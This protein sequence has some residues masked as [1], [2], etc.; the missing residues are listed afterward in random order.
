MIKI[1][2]AIAALACSSVIAIAGNT[3][4][5]TDRNAPIVLPI[6]P[7]NKATGAPGAIDNMGIGQTT[8]APGNFTNLVAQ[9]VVNQSMPSA[10][11]VVLPTGLGTL[12]MYIGDVRLSS[13]TTIGC[14]VVQRADGAT[15][16]VGW[17]NDVCDKA[18]ADRFANGTALTILTKLDQSGNSNNCTNATAA[19][20]PAYTALNE[21][22]NIRPTSL[23]GTQGST[24]VVTFLQCPS[25]INRNAVTV[26]DVEAAR[27]ALSQTVRWEFTDAGFTTALCQ[28]F[29]PGSGT[30]ALSIGNCGGGAVGGVLFTRSNVNITAVSLSGTAGSITQSNT[31]SQFANATVVTTQVVGG[32]QFGHSVTGTAWNESSDIYAIAIFGASHT[33]LQMTSTRSALA[34]SFPVPTVF[35]NRLVYGGS[36]LITSAFDT[37]NQNAPWQ[38]GFGRNTTWE[39]YIP[40]VFGQTLATEFTNRA[41]YVNLFDATKAQNIVVIDA[42]SNDISGQTSFASHAAAVAYANTLY[43]GTT[44][45]FVAALKAVGYRVVVPTTIARGSF[46]SGTGNFLDDARVQYNLNVVNGAA[47]NGYF[48]SNRAGNGLFATQGSALNTQ[49]YQPDQT[50]LTNLCYGVLVGIDAAAIGS[51]G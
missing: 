16:T 28:L 29:N 7:P 42:P 17:L 15:M 38:G 24:T 19:T 34:Q 50:H 43:S 21:Q 40:A 33:A 12:A 32:F 49:C 18:S 22:G 44:L 9:S 4:F 20:Q 13:N 45:P 41:N 36:S 5:L 31:N 6:S 10:T 47:A 35:R 25:A 51:G 2:V 48:L 11:P 27:M 8:P 30:V 1:V 46:N 26:Y 3:G 39:T 37:L 14:E 23:V